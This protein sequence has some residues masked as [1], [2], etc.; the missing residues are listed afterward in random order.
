MY[1][2][3]FLIAACKSFCTCL[4]IKKGAFSFIKVVASNFLAI[5]NL[6][7]ISASERAYNKDKAPAKLHSFS[8]N[9]HDY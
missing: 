2:N 8:V 1:R 6:M 3:H 9:S 7:S 5:S 4:A